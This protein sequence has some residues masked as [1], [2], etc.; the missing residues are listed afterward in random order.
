MRWGIGHKR[1]RCFHQMSRDGRCELV[2]CWGRNI[3]S[4]GSR[5]DTRGTH[6]WRIWVRAC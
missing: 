6:M 3:D 4:L 5:V 1:G 2:P